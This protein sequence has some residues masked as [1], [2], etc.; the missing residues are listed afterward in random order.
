MSRYE[1]LEG[2]FRYEELSRYAGLKKGKKKKKGKTRY[3]LQSIRRA[4]DEL[5]ETLNATYEH[6][7]QSIDKEKQAYVHRIFQCII[8]S[9]R[10]LRVEELME[11]L[12]IQLDAETIPRYYEDWRPADAGEALLSTCST[13]I[14]IV[15]DHGSRIVQFSHFSVQEYLTS[16][17]LAQS[18]YAS[19]HHVRLKAAHAFLARACLTIL[20]RLDHHV[21]RDHLKDFPLATYAAQHW[22]DHAQFENTSSLIPDEIEL[23]FD[24]EKPHFAA[25]IWVYDVDKYP[26]GAH[27]TSAHPEKPRAV[28][29]Y[30]AALC[31]F[32]GIIEHLTVTHPQDVNARCGNRATPLHAALHNGHLEVARSLLERGADINARNYTGGT[33]LHMALERGD[34][35]ALQLLIDRGADPNLQG[36]VFEETPLYMAS[37]N[38]RVE[39][40][41]LLLRR[42]ADPNHQGRW[43]GT[44]LHGASENG[45][46]DVVRLLIEYG[47]NV[48]TRGKDG[49]TSLHRASSCGSIETTRVLL[50]H[51]ANV[52][53]RDERDLTPLYSASS[54]GQLEVMQLLLDRGANVNTQDRFLVTPLRRAAEYGRLDVARVL[55]EYGA[56]LHIRDNEGRTPFQFAMDK[57]Y[58]ELARLLSEHTSEGT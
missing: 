33:P 23:L 2:L 4:L 9:I 18:N 35:E 37:Y 8:A 47:A 3:S 15:N 21:D 20:L 12:A 5:P 30:Y 14:A 54:V 19:H 17:R 43:S 11:V 26:G 38:G 50:E 58:H 41:R 49:G 1:E 25:W 6:T 10:P 28:P 45:H 48:N 13:L 42:G 32:C 44:S 24:Q 27:M 36:G 22:T 31:G 56:D 55:L 40:S 52:N 46:H 16:T 39:A 57:G 7:L 29:L 34:T 51:G 53:A